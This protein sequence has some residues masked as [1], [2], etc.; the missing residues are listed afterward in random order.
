RRVPAADR[1]HARGLSG[2]S[3]RMSTPAAVRSL[4]YWARQYRRT[5]RTAVISSLVNP[6]LFLAAMGVGLGHLVDRN[7]ATRHATLG[8]ASYLVFL[9]PG[10][11]AA[12]AMQTAASDSTFPV[13]AAIKWVR[14]YHAML[15][16]P[17]RVI[18]VL[19][20]HLSWIALRL[21]GSSMAF[22]AVIAAFGATHGWSVLLAVP[23]A[24]LTG[25]ALSAPLVAY[26]AFTETE[27]HFPAIFRFGVMPMF[28]FSGT[29][30]P[31]SQLPALVRPVAYVTPIW[32]GVELCRGLALGTSSVAAVA[33]HVAYLLVW[34]AVGTG[35]A[36]L[37]FKRRLR[38]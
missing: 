36:L 15:A 9:A 2:E 29:F 30:F 18:D 8:G 37:S 7:G 23:A 22:V 25:M 27:A 6:V 32:H 14:Q 4:E 10:L 33:G 12:T 24:V 31:V 3:A 26:A 5:W 21:A 38:S 34:A 16:T 1:P 13:M 17:L 19:A 35:L 28:L 11:L 20:G